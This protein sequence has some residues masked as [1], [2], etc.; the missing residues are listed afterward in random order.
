MI[1]PSPRSKSHHGAAQITSGTAHPNESH[2]SPHEETKSI[3]NSHDKSIRPML[4]YALS[5]LVEIEIL[6]VA[7]NDRPM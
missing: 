3:L 4:Q 7:R 2:A 1:S 6:N 5:D